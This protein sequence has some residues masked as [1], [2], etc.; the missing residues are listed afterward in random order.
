MTIQTVFE[1]LNPRIQSILSSYDITQPTEP[2]IKAIP[3]ILEGENVLLIAP[4]GH[5]KTEAALLP[6][7]HRFLEEVKDKSGSKGVSILY[8]TPLRAL[9]RDMLKRTIKWGE[10]LGI[11]I[12]V[13]HGDTSKSERATQAKYPSDMLITTPETL[14]ILFMGSRT[15]NHLRSV[16]YVIVDEVH[17]LADDERGAQLSV[18]LERLYEITKEK[19]VDFQRIG[20]SATV[21]SPAEVAHYL[22]GLIDD[23]PRGVSI[24][25][26][27]VPK[28]VDICVEYPKVRDED[29]TISKDLSMEPVSF[30][31][32]RRCYELMQDHKS[33]LI[34]TNTRDGAEVLASRFHHWKGDDAL[35]GV[36]HGSLSKEVR[37]ESEND[38][39]D[40]KLKALICTSSLELGIDIGDTDLVVQYNSPREVT[41]LLQRV[42]RSGHQIG[43]VSRGVIL[44]VNPDDI[45]ESLVVARRALS[46]ELEDLRIRENQLSVLANQIISITLEHRE[47]SV[48]RLYHIIKRSYV[49][50]KLP[51]EVFRKILDHLTNHHLL[52]YKDGSIVAARRR[53]SRIYFLD[54]ISMIPDEQSYNVV[55]ITSRKR[56]GKLDERFVIDY[57]SEGSTFI[58]HGRSWRIIKKEEDEILVSP[59]KEIGTVPSW[60]G[61]DIPVPFEV[62]LEVGKLRRIISESD[63]NITERYPCDS[64]TISAFS[65][66]IKEQKKKGFTVPDDRIITIETEDKSITINACFGTKVN[67]TLSTLISSML[68]QSIGESVG[69][70]SDPYRINL[71]LPVRIPAERIKNIIMQIKPENVEYLL[72]KI[73]RNTPSVRHTFIHMARK[74]GVI[75]K[76]FD[77]RMITSRRLSL[78]FN[79][80]IIMNEAIDK[81]IWERMDINSTRYVLSCIQD[82]SISVHEQRLSPISLAG[83]DT[84]KGLMLP[85]QPTRAILSTLKKRLDETDLTLVCLNCKRTFNTVTIRSENHLTCSSCGAK[86]IA[87]MSPNDKN[88]IKILSKKGLTNDE[89]KDLAR[90]HKNASLVLSYGV[91]AVYALS[92]RG[93]GPDTA[94]RI[95]R[96]YNYIDLV[97]SEETKMRL[98]QDILKA[99]LNYARTRGFWDK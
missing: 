61:E 9:N 20:L 10:A 39:K 64:Y 58:L 86:K 30:A 91:F 33:T 77:Y 74:F 46:G 80:S 2:Q 60:I 72:R 88:T 93:I 81:I 94:A 5:G 99:E 43:R 37:I 59:I 69:V 62:A 44:A 54:N 21:G 19:G 35:I 51:M 63:D 55:D 78:L 11:R 56:I 57:G 50:N 6:V 52:F 97:R 96:R 28:E 67:E 17:E 42:G 31:S 79:D 12:A 75:S 34:F 76:D 49:F 87:V 45:A 53:R 29:S 92:G 90:L 48:G 4:T 83:Y 16:R 73:L 27:D 89:K 1:L 68:A 23:K 36:H 84:I 71:E 7:F 26:V 95:L 38:F 8:I 14:Q 15:R 98:F 32:M 22:G 41:R 40:G 65:E 13:R 18:A 66:Q 25:K 82:G 70:N 47:I 85:Q 24:I 3:R